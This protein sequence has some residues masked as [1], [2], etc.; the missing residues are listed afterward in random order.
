MKKVFYTEWAYI[1]GVTILALGTAIMEKADC[2]VSMVVAPALILYTKL[3]EI[4]SFFTFGMAEYLL[5]FTLIILLTIVM[6]KFKISYI[7]S[8][9][10]TIIYGIILDCCVFVLSFITVED[11]WLRIIFYI[12]G[13]FTT[14]LGVALMFHT[15]ISPAVY[16]LFVKEVQ[17]GYELDMFKTKTTYDCV[18]CVVAIIMSFSL[19]GFGN[20]VGVKLG[21][22]VCAFVNG[23]I[24]S[25]YSK[26]LE[27]KFEFR[28]GTK[29]HRFYK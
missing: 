20:F 14:A 15:Y 29:L 21:T 1:L 3:S 9:L 28:D 16:E 17:E 8:F 5:Q 6:R 7:L 24:I 26:F 22:I 23:F 12:V 19:F 2:G 13:L 25:K 11:M 18:S 4:F 27:S 10:T